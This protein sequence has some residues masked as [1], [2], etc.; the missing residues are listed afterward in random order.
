MPEASSGFDEGLVGSPA[1]MSRPVSDGRRSLHRRDLHRRDRAAREPADRAAGAL[2]WFGERRIPNR[3]HHHCHS[4]TSDTVVVMLAERVSA[5]A[6]AASPVIR[7]RRLRTPTDVVLAL[8]A[9]L[10]PVA[11]VDLFLVPSWTPRAAIVLLVVPVGLAELVRAARARDRAA[12]AA[13]AFMA[14]LVSSTVIAGVPAW[15]LRGGIARDSGLLFIGGAFTMWS[16]ARGATRGARRE[17]A[18]CSVVGVVVSAAVGI[19]QVLVEPSGFLQMIGQRPSGLMVNPVYFGAVCAGA[20][21]MLVHSYAPRRHA[22]LVLGTIALLGASVS[23]SG[24]RG[25]LLGLVV[26]VLLLLGRP[27]R[28]R[29]SAAPSI[30]LVAGFAAGLG[31]SRLTGGRD[32]ADRLQI[33]S[34]GR[35]GIWRYA[36]EAFAERP[37][38]GHG[39]GQFRAA[40]QQHFEPAFVRDHAFDFVGAAWPDAH[41]LV[42]QYAVVGGLV[43]LVPAIAFVVAIMRVSRGPLLVAVATVSVTWMLQPATL[44]TVP[45]AMLWLGLSSAPVAGRRVPHGAGRFGVLLIAVGALLTVTLVGFDVR[46]RDASRSSA[47]GT[48]ADWASI[49]PDDPVLASTASG[50]AAR[51]GQRERAATWARKAVRLEPWDAVTRAQYAIRLADAGETELALDEARRAIEIDQ[52]N[53][54]ALNVAIVLGNEFDDDALVADGVSRLCQITPEGC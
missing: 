17:I 2:G 16:A 5:R 15:N 3:R 41:N 26:A 29:T 7:A 32:V 46:L 42:L 39:L 10:L 22:G 40:V 54:F 25:A 36:L 27:G 1:A 52:W 37:L 33:G 6:G 45:L 53:S 51:V 38:T 4:S 19:V 30:A 23:L 48:F 28:L 18:A 8:A 35:S 34:D 21:A 12:W 47:A 24:S 11:Y 20:A 44:V 13:I 50:V 31:L 49:A 14:A 43:A 9:F